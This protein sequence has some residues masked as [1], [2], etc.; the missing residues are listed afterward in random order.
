MRDMG[1]FIY[2]FSDSGRDKLLALQ[3]EM[4]KCDAEKHIFVFANKES[5]C[6]A[7]EDFPYALT[8]TLTF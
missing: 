8:D 2:V 7:G 6:F 1:A 5:Q 4:L 3:Y